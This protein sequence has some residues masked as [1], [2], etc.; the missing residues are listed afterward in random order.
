MDA[1]FAGH[2]EALAVMF[3]DYHTRF[4]LKN[5]RKYVRRTAKRSW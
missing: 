2:R 5:V 1:M 3:D 4:L